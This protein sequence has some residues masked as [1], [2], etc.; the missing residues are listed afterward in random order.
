MTIPTLQQTRRSIKLPNGDVKFEV[1]SLVTHPGDLPFTELFVLSIVDPGD[2]KDD[3]LARIATPFDIRQT[4]SSNPTKYIKVVSTDIINIAGDPFARIA[5]IDDITGLARDRTIAVN[6]G[7]NEF[8]SSSVT[9]IYDTLTTAEAAYKQIISRLSDLV[10]TWRTSYGAFVTS[11]SSIYLLPRNDSSVEDERVAT[12]K[13]TKENRIKAENDRN[14][15]ASLKEDCTKDCKTNKVIYD[16][17]LADVLFLESARNLLV[18]LPISDARSFALGL[19]AYVTDTRSYERLL[20]NKRDSLSVYLGLLN[21]CNSRCQTLAEALSNTER[22]LASS[23]VAER[24][25]LAEV[26]EVCPTFDPATV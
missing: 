19:D 11:P 24:E 20:Q 17:I 14:L 16:F 7:K 3:V 10:N 25:A 26:Y 23:I 9:L 18:S 8:L 1:T 13:T 21:Q 12:Y 5:N 22:V 2:P 15:A 4:D 6:T